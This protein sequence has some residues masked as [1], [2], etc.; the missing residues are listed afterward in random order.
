MDVWAFNP[1]LKTEVER[2][3]T[4]Q[5][6]VHALG[7]KGP[8][9]V[10][11]GRTLSV[12]VRAPSFRVEPVADTVV[13]DGTLANASFTLVL[14]TGRATRRTGGNRDDC[15]WRCSVSRSCT[16]SSISVKCR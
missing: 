14:R 10:E 4:G 6:R 16:L 1:E 2:E 3:A 8:V 15:V 7:S 11:V 9:V 12:S 5:G 13:W